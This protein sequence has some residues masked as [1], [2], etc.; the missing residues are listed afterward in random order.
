MLY[1]KSKNRLI[2]LRCLKNKLCFP[3][4]K[5]VEVKK[6]TSKTLLYYT[7]KEAVTVN[8]RQAYK[9]I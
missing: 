4:I 2:F 8:L 6:N 3:I 9:Q 7:I 5:D 1:K